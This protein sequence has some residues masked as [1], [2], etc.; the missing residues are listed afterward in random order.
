MRCGLP[1]SQRTA[2]AQQAPSSTAGAAQPPPASSVG[3]YSDPY[4]PPGPYPPP[5]PHPPSGPYPPPG[6]HTQPAPYAQPGQYAQPAPYPP[7]AYAPPGT[8]TAATGPYPA[9]S[10]YAAPG[11][12]APALTTSAS[13]PGA[14]QGDMSSAGRGSRLAT[15][16]SLGLAALLSL[17]YAVWAFT[18]R[19][20]IFSDFASSRAVGVGEA[21]SNDRIDTSWLIVAGV[22][23]L[24]ALAMWVV[25]TSGGDT[26]RSLLDALGLTLVGVGAVVAVIGL[27]LATRIADA[28]DQ[29]SSGDR[30]VTA[31]LVTG[32]GFALLGIGLVVG[33]LAL[34]ARPHASPPPPAAVA[35]SY[36]GW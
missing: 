29:V 10:L 8:N 14:D 31:S 17:G 11:L 26:K 19:R 21:R 27:A 16:A 4:A 18:A 34:R 28:T 5:G 20:G 9:S 33:L 1:V 2:G 32:S 15:L 24:V 35:G 12:S 30:G 25:R 6:Q 36:P 7:D 3:S 22:V 13:Y 23:S